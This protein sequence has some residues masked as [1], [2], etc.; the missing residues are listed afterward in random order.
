ME[1]GGLVRLVGIDVD[2]TLVGTSGE[3]SDSVWQAAERARAAGIRLALCS[4]RPAFGVTLDYARRLDALGWHIFQNGASVL[5]LASGNS[6]STALPQDVLQEL[7]EQSRRTGDLLELYGDQDYASES[8]A[9]WAQEHAALL[10]VPFTVRS[11][12][13]LSGNVVRAQWVVAR[14]AVERVLAAA[15]DG[16]EIAVSGSPLMPTAAF[17]GMTRAGVNK[18]ASL[19]AVADAYG[20]DLRDAMYVGDSDNDLPALRIVGHPVAMA[21][22]SPAVLELA[23]TV[24]GHVDKDGLVQALQLAID[25]AAR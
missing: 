2:G 14:D 5:D 6:R 10:G 22:S 8:T 11:F 4:G 9:V 18:G 23:P 7:I 20:I 25:A 15:H 17:I 1:E 12:D 19:R 3:V 16:L 21:N 24:V 13:S